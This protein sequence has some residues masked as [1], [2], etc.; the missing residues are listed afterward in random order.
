MGAVASDFFANYPS[1][2]NIAKG[3]CGQD[4]SCNHDRQ[5][6]GCVMK[7]RPVEVET[8]VVDAPVEVEVQEEFQKPTKGQI[9]KFRPLDCAKQLHDG[10]RYQI[11]NTIK[12]LGEN[13]NYTKSVL[14]KMKFKR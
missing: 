13:G 12:V 1:L 7:N 5:W 4:G 6:L 10:M 3:W 8:Q 14:N 2:G 11:S 9:A